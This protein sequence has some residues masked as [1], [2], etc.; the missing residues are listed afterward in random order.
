MK[1]NI[2]NDVLNHVLNHVSKTNLLKT[3]NHFNKKS[4]SC[5]RMDC[6]LKVVCR[7]T[8][9]SFYYCYEHVQ[10]HPHPRENLEI[11]E[12]TA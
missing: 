10:T 7:C 9:C 11:V 4:I 12:N 6:L 8:E 3:S 5:H 2:H 1:K